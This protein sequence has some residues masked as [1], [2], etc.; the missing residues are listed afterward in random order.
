MSKSL[1]FTAAAALAMAALLPVPA[2]VQAAGL[3]ASP[4]QVSGRPAAS[5]FDGVVEAVR[6]TVIAAQVP[7]GGAP[8]ETGG[9]AAAVA[10]R[11]HR[12]R[13]N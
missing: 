1:L 6:Q 2:A 11:G 3:P 4:A 7:G 12:R 10:G 9:C 8:R 13:S 5:G